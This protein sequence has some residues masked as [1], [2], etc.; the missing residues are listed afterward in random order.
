MLLKIKVFVL[1]LAYVNMTEERIF[2][3][4]KTTP[5]NDLNVRLSAGQSVMLLF[6][7]D[8]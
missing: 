3:S 7:L 4:S 1:N 2:F 5:E 8:Y 6:K